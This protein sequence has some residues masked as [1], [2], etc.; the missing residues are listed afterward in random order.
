MVM[1]LDWHRMRY[2]SAWSKLFR[3]L[4][5]F[6]NFF[7]LLRYGKK[8]KKFIK[9]TC[10]LKKTHV[11]SQKGMEEMGITPGLWFTYQSIDISRCIIEKCVKFTQFC[12]KMTHIYSISVNLH[13]YYSFCIQLFIPSFLKHERRKQMVII[14]CKEKE[15]ILKFFKKIDIL[16]K[17]DVKQII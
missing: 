8:K 16:M 7:L 9:G 17:C 4:M 12:L 15:T 11:S 6:F 13:L 14:V 10:G 3:K 2:Y 5:F 1:D